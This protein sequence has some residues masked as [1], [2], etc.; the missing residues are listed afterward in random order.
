[1]SHNCAVN[2]VGLGLDIADYLHAQGVVLDP[3]ADQ[4]RGGDKPAVF[5]GPMPDQPDRA[6]GIIGPWL[7]STDSDTNPLVR[8][9]IAQRTE[10]W[11]FQQLT[12]DSGALLDA[13]HRDQPFPLTAT[14]RVMYCE[15]VIT[16]PPIQDDNDR[17]R[18]VTT[19]SARL[20]PPA[21]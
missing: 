21:I 11:D 12:H 14:Q 20:N 2:I 13:L 1:M 19:Y 16:D 17:W 9:M 3:A 5:V 8:F 4:T 6:I 7:D 10:P 18:R 15:Q